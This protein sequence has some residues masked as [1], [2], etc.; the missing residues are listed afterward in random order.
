MAEQRLAQRAELSQERQQHITNLT[1]VHSPKH[2][3]LH[4]HL[5]T[6]ANL[7]PYL[8]CPTSSPFANIKHIQCDPTVLLESGVDVYASDQ[9]MQLNSMQSDLHSASAWHEST[10]CNSK[11]AAADR[12]V[13]QQQLRG[14][15]PQRRAS[16]TR[17]AACK[18]PFRELKLRGS[19][20]H[21][22]VYHACAGTKH[23]SNCAKLSL[24][25]S[26]FSSCK[27]C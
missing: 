19:S 3:F 10:V 23:L 7:P 22:L 13:T 26:V 17:S 24:L 21:W 9:G 8:W 14:Q 11:M 6:L 2:R 1:Q 27:S 5:F 18:R 20:Q 15:Q 4:T 25:H 16:G 12:S